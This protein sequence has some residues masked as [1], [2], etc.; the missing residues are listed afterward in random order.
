[1]KMSDAR[2]GIYFYSRDSSLACWLSFGGGFTHERCLALSFASVSAAADF[3]V[4]HPEETRDGYVAFLGFA[5]DSW[6]SR[7]AL[8]TAIATRTA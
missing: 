2:Y 1:M 4:D 7:D 6:L 8:R 5:S 3:L